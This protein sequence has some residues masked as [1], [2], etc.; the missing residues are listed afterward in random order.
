MTR[1]PFK[2]MPSHISAC[3]LCCRANQASLHPQFP[4][5]KYH[6]ISKP[7]NVCL[8]VTDSIL[9]RQMTRP[10]TWSNIWKIVWGCDFV[11]AP[12]FLSR[13]PPFDKNWPTKGN[14]YSSAESKHFLV[15]PAPAAYVKTLL[16]DWSSL[17][18]FLAADLLVQLLGWL[19]Q[20]TRW[21]PPPS[22]FVPFSFRMDICSSTSGS[23]PRADRPGL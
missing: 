19:G 15:V 13:P 23:S 12:R 17:P 14:I 21:L 11:Y 6:L 5:I 3:T 16:N 18:V 20:M 7:L 10:N 4:P 9:E 22:T 8:P 1:D 2:P